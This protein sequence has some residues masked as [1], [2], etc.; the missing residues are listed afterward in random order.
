VN[1]QKAEDVIV[2]FSLTDA[3]ADEK[4]GKD[5]YRITEVPS[6]SG[7]RRPQ[8]LPSLHLHEGSF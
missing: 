7:K 1:W 2:N 3:A 4:F 8:A 5:G 6:E